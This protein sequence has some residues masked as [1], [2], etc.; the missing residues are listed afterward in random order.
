V[1]QN[2]HHI[3]AWEADGAEGCQICPW[4]L[5]AGNNLLQQVGA[6]EMEKQENRLL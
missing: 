6:E 4:R 1:E 2:N 5:Y 3:L